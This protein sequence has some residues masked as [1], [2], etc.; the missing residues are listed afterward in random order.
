[1]D[2]LEQIIADY[3]SGANGTKCIERAFVAGQ[4]SVEVSTPRKMWLKCSE[5][6][7]KAQHLIN[8]MCPTCWAEQ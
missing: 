5:C 1:M 3:S 6:G 2:E 4:K 8:T 7:K